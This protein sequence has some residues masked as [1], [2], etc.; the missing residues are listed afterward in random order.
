MRSWEKFSVPKFTSGF[1]ALAP[2]ALYLDI[3]KRVRTKENNKKQVFA[4]ILSLHNELIHVLRSKSKLYFD[5]QIQ[6]DTAKGFM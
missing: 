5:H 4:T 2:Q 1:G 3:E 6:H